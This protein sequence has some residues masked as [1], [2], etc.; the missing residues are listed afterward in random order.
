MKDAMPDHDLRLEDLS[1]SFGST[2]ALVECNAVIPR[3]ATVALVGSNG[4]GKSTLM[5]IIAGLLAPSSGRVLIDGNPVDA[6]CIPDHLAFLT[7]DR[8]LYRSFTVN[9]MIR[10]SEALNVDWDIAYARELIDAAGIDRK[11]RIKTLSG[12]QHSRVAIALALAQRPSVL[13]LDEPMSDLDPVARRQV[14]D[15]LAAETRT[16]GTTTILSSHIVTELADH[17]DHLL[18]IDKGR[19]LASGALDNL[20]PETRSTAERATAL[21]EFVVQ[22]LAGGVSA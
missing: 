7:Q 3:G 16:N 11:A 18:M 9:E 12:G 22:R 19:I 17:C 8:P 14:R 6:G 13:L 1:K 21:E 2:A 10:A 4:A 5:S 20:L 15:L